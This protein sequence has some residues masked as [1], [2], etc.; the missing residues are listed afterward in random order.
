MSWSDERSEVRV[1]RVRELQ[2]V[3]YRKCEAHLI[4]FNY[5][6]SSIYF[7]KFWSQKMIQFQLDKSIES[8]KS[9]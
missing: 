5:A 6:L 7:E 1:K 2:A 9:L 4:E 8:V 3:F